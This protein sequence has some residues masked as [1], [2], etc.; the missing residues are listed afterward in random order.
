MGRVKDE[1]IEKEEAAAQR[2]ANLAIKKGW[3]CGICGEYIEPEDEM[4]YSLTGRCGLHAHMM[5]K[6]D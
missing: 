5:D 6:D 4:V 2:W 1:I 3:Q